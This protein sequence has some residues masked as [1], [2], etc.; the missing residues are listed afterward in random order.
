V[1]ENSYKLVWNIL[2]CNRLATR[3]TNKNTIG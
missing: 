3:W 2:I 1:Q